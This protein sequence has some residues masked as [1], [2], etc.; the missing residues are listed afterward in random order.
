VVVQGRQ[1]SLEVLEARTVAET[2]Q[3]I[4]L[5]HVPLEASREF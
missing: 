3:A 5:G 1:R 2:Q 4:D